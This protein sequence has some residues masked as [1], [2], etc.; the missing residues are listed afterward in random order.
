[1]QRCPERGP[2]SPREPESFLH[3]REKA[4]EGAKNTELN[5]GIR[6]RGFFR[7][8]FRVFRGNPQLVLLRVF[9]FFAATPKTRSPKPEI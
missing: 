5:R 3:G 9:V 1:V 8:H 6:E 4:Q 2:L 7:L